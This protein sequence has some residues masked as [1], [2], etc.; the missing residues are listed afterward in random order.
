MIFCTY[1]L[2]NNSNFINDNNPC[3]GRKVGLI[4]NNYCQIPR[5][6]VMK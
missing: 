3:T 6:I 2:L 1:T 4:H 5:N